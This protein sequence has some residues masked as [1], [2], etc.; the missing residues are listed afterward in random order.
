MT[1]FLL[2]ALSMVDSFVEKR[3]SYGI[4]RFPNDVK[5]N[6]LQYNDESFISISSQNKKCIDDDD[7]VFSRF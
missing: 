1:S 2:L 5:T 6:H 7:G 3:V 4:K